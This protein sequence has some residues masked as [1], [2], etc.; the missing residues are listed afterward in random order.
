MQLTHLLWAEH[1]VLALDDDLHVRLALPV[2]NVVRHLQARGGGAWGGEGS[3]E[4]GREGGSCH[5]P[6]FA[7]TRWAAVYRCKP[8]PRLLLLQEWKEAGTVCTGTGTGR[9]RSQ[10]GRVN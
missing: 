8:P 7:G 9:R 5:A 3:G 1:L 10:L 6:V 2:D 4:G